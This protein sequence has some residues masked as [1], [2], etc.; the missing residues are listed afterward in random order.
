LI[1]ITKSVTYANSQS[2]TT[3]PD[4]G[5]LHQQRLHGGFGLFVIVNEMPLSGYLL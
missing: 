4:T 3:S 1:L 5:G 2:G